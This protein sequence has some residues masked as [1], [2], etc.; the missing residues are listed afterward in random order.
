MDYTARG[1]TN[2]E[3]EQWSNCMRGIEVKKG[4]LI[5]NDPWIPTT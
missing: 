1:K 3:Q 4:A 2:S 5:I